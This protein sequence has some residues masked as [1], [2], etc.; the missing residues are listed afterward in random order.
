MCQLMK[1]FQDLFP[2][3]DYRKEKKNKS[4][5]QKENAQFK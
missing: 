4:K 2:L 3:S 1:H 5:I